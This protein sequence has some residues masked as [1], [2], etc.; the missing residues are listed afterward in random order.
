[1]AKNFLQNFKRDCYQELRDT[2]I[3]RDPRQ[4]GLINTFIQAIQNQTFI[5]IQ[6][7]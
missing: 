5:E 7:N 2:G 1:M 3:L 6:N 4:Y